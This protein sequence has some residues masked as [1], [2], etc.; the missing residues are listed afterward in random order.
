M[1][2]DHVAGPRHL[3]RIEVAARHAHKTLEARL[4]GT[5]SAAV[6]LPNEGRSAGAGIQC[7]SG[8]DQ[9][10]MDVHCVVWLRGCASVD[11]QC[12]TVPL[13]L[14]MRVRV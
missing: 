14:G 3:C 5:R 12:S 13:P 7:Y 11:G 2:D 9:H 6:W 8:P 4:H 10:L 1:H